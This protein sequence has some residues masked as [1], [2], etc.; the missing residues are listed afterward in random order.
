M[1]SSEVMGMQKMLHASELFA[2]ICEP[3]RARLRR[4]ESSAELCVVLRAGVGRICHL[5]VKVLWA[6]DHTRS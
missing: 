4:V 6:Q 2:W 3:L 5:E 1:V